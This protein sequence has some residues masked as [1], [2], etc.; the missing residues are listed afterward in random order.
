[1]L[2]DYGLGFRPLR[3]P[4]GTIELAVESLEQTTDVW[5]VGWELKDS[6]QKTAPKLFEFV[7]VELNDVKLTDVLHGISVRSEVPVYIDHYRIEARGIDLDKIVVSYPLR[8]ASWSQ[9]LRGITA[10]NRLIND[11]GIDEQGQPFV[12]ITT[13][14]PGRRER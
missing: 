12:W 10:P 3:T 4:E 7:P 13:L 2:N 8:R 9:L 1:V 5:P 6:R 11:L 14:E